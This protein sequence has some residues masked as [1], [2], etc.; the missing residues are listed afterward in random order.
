MLLIL[1]LKVLVDTH[2]YARLVNAICHKSNRVYIETIFGQF[3]EFLF[4]SLIPELVEQFVVV[5]LPQCRFDNRVQI[6]L[7]LYPLHPLIKRSHLDINEFLSSKG[8]Q[9]AI[10]ACKAGKVTP[11]N[12]P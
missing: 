9:R 8:T 10:M 5:F 6:L 2:S 7:R 12:M 11:S 4:S 3:E 1:L